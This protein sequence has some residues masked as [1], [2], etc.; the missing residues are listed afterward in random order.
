MRRGPAEWQSSTAALGLSRADETGVSPAA[1]GSPSIIR[2]LRR[3]AKGVRGSHGP[4]LE[5]D[6]RHRVDVLRSNPWG[7][8]CRVD[9]WP[10]HPQ[11]AGLIPLPTR[12][13]RTRV[14][15]T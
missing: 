9:A 7:S 2:Q 1:S 3:E 15:L 6:L 13:C 10:G 5:L 12:A 14:G 4:P 11:E 8:R